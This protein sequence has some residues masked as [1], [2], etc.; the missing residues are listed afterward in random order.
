MNLFTAILLP[1]IVYA[2]FFDGP[3]EG[4]CYKIVEYEN[5]GR[6]TVEN[7]DI[8]E[9]DLDGFNDIT[10][11]GRRAPAIEVTEENYFKEFLTREL[12]MKL[13]TSMLL[14]T[15]VYAA[16]FDGPKE[17]E[18]YKIVEYENTGRY[19]VE[20]QDIPEEDFDGF[21]DITDVKELVI[22]FKRVEAI[23]DSRAHQYHILEGGVKG[24][25]P[26]TIIMET[27][28]FHILPHMITLEEYNKKIGVCKTLRFRQYNALFE[29][30]RKN[31]KLLNV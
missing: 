6:Y 15:V 20:N 30:M 1:T 28:P 16:F 29:D 13:L 9:E 18:C 5:T 2:A 10:V 22:T 25:E 12:K 24:E 23:K 8:P 11:M 7:H 3:K 26:K 27:V 21:N 31:H 4:E 17:G 14:P 19:T